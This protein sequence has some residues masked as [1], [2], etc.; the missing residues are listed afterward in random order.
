M[1]FVHKNKPH[2]YKDVGKREYSELRNIFIL[3]TH[4][5]YIKKKC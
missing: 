4:Y 2:N 5:L 3:I 1:N